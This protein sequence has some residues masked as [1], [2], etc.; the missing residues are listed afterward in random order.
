M[1]QTRTPLG[2]F[3]ILFG[4]ISILDS[5]TIYAGSD[6]KIFGDADPC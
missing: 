4:L 6:P 1:N 3:I 5:Q 2:A